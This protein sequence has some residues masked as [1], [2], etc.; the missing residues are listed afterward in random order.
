MVCSTPSIF[1]VM[2]ADNFVDVLW[3]IDASEGVL[4]GFIGELNHH[5]PSR[6]NQD[7]LVHPLKICP[8]QRNPISTTLSI[9]SNEPNLIC[10]V[11]GNEVWVVV[12]LDSAHPL[13]N[14]A[15]LVLLQCWNQNWKVLVDL[16]ENQR[17]CCLSCKKPIYVLHIPFHIS[18]LPLSVSI[19]FW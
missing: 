2:E 6:R 3:L 17:V 16:A 4:K 12:V 15:V 9:V 10:P 7:V 11:K 18:Y 14:R 8:R 13:S 1:K 19:G 5:L